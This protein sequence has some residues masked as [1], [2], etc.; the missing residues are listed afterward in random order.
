M[1]TKP[2]AVISCSIRER[3]VQRYSLSEFNHQFL[4][5]VTLGMFT[6]VVN[7]TANFAAKYSQ[8]GIL[9]KTDLT[10]MCLAFTRSANCR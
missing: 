8:R 3:R 4:W 2:D 9:V 6:R 7:F 10:K 1:G 5:T